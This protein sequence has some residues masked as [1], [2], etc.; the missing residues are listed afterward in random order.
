LIRRALLLLAAV[1]MGA[2]AQTVQPP[3]VERPIQPPLRG[4]V[5]PRARDGVEMPRE[6]SMPG[7]VLRPPPG[8]DP[9]IQAPVPVPRPNTT[10]VIPPPGAP[11][12]TPR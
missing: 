8:V 10:P 9:G 7:R 5:P 3:P 4:E 6:P 11:S 2:R 12:T 1:P